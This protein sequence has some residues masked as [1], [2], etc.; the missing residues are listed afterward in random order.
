[1]GN[2]RREG[3]VS[4][5]EKPFDQLPG[6]QHDEVPLVRRERHGARITKDSPACTKVV[7]HRA[8]DAIGHVCLV[9]GLYLYVRNRLLRDR[10]HRA[11]R[12]ETNMVRAVQ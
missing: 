6:V 9:H 7:R 10:E 12:D 1:M 2:T 5:L 4:G 11:T 3:R 8:V